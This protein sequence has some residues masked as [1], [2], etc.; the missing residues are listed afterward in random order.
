MAKCFNPRSIK[1]NRPIERTGEL[2][3]YVNVPCGKCENC[4]KNRRMQWCFRME[5][6]MSVSKTAYFVTMT[7]DEE[8]VP[9]NYGQT[10][11]LKTTLDCKRL[12]LKEMGKAPIKDKYLKKMKLK[13]T[14]W[15]DRSGQGF[16]KR[17]RS[18][19][20]RNRKWTREMFYSG[21]TW[22]DKMKYYL[23]GEY[24]EKRGRCHMHAIIFNVEECF[25]K[26]SWPWGD[27]QVVKATPETIAYCTKYMD[28]W[29]D[30]KQDWR[31]PSEYNVQSEELGIG[32]VKR[33]M[34]FYKKNLDIN[35]VVNKQGVRI[36]MPRYYRM[37]MLNEQE[38][39]YQI[40][41]IDKELKRLKQKEIELLGEDGYEKKER[42]IR[43]TAKR[44]FKRDKGK[45]DVD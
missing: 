23:V 38:I 7:Y 44:K 16:I 24:G 9:W 21:L 25:I 45:R 42:R 8:N 29:K 26:E 41:Y 14:G 39:D 4:I 20:E 19:H 32:F 40:G 5:E 27:V 1:L 31:R 34:N 6:E 43:A 10:V 12:H 35:Y 17:L 22:E 18:K 28:K 30:K 36:P 15:K 37:K 33:M 13:D 11:L 3:M 2:L